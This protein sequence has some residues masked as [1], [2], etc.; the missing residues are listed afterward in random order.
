M[1]CIA[2]FIVLAVCGIFSAA[3][4]PMARKAWHCVAR[5]LTFRPCDI[6]FSEEVKGKLLGRIILDHPTLARFLDRWI[7]VFAWVFV[8]LSV[9]SLVAVSLAGLNLFIYDTCNPQHP[10]N[11]SLSGEACSVAT[12]D[13]GFWKSLGETVSLI[14]SRLRTWK[15]EEYT[16]PDNSWYRP[17]NPAKPTALEI[18]DPGCHACADLFGNI[19][20][21]GFEDRYN[22]TYIA[23]PIPQA[24]S[25]NG[26][27][28]IHSYLITT[29]LEA[30]KQ[31]PA[32]HPTSPVA[33]DW[34]LLKRIFT[35]VNASGGKWQ[36]VFDLAL[37]TDQARATLD[38]FCAD[39]GY[40]AEQRQRI[41]Q[42]AGSPEIAAKIREHRAIVEQRIHTIRIPTIL[43]NGRRYDRVIAPDQL[44]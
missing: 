40:S 10:E 43:F 12:T 31:V 25:W 29:Y 14:P 26:Y 38:A 4:R 32:A 13:P 36:E 30:M 2:A 33:P 34:R 21:A 17:W 15:P 11:C 39:F 8:G 9:W 20:K 35:G 37:T 19:R 16:G 42:L 1:F 44:K 7:D 24:N 27:K 3:W 22:L 28:F 5:R 23:Y 18:V 41:A 6:N